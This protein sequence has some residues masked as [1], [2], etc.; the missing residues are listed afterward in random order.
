M[1]TEGYDAVE[2]LMESAK[3]AGQPEEVKH[4]PRKSEDLEDAWYG[5]P[6]SA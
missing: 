2:A 4:A 5:Y 3:W 6:C 1:F